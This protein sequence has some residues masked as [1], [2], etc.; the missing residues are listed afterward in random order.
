MK[1]SDS[2]FLL[3]IS[4]PSGVGKSSVYTPVMKSDPSLRFSVSCTTRPKRPGE[5]DGQHY[6][7]L[8]RAEFERQRAEKAFVESFT[9]H[10]ELYGTRREDLDQMLAKGLTPVLDVDVQGG[11][12]ILSTFKEHVVSVFL[13]P[14]SFEELE[15]RLR[16]RG[17]E[18]AEAVRVRLENAR[19][20]VDY[21]RHYDYW[22]V[23]DELKSAIEDLRAILRAER[24]RRVR[25]PSLPLSG[26]SNAA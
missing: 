21:A 19:W 22:L 1:E 3:L 5:V 20:E 11:E 26:P 6:H 17:T 16:N 12:R 15:A 23:N 10:E 9:V 8:S 24:R 14:P 13:F 7:F 4:G 25:W 18:D 2:Q